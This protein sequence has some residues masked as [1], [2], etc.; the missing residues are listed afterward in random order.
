M[1]LLVCQCIY[2][3]KYTFKQVFFYFLFIMQLTGTRSKLLMQGIL[4]NYCDRGYRAVNLLKL[5][6]TKR[7]FHKQQKHSPGGVL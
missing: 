6:S 2:Y 4:W 7:T 3:M 1:N 5:R